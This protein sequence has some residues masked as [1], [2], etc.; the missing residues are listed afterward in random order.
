MQFLSGF[1][2]IIKI[3]KLI[4]ALRDLDMLWIFFR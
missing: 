4:G 1:P 3:A 2:E